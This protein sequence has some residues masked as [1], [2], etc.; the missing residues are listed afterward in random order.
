MSTQNWNG[1]IFNLGSG[2]N[3]SVNEVA[4]M[5]NPVSIKYIPAYPGEA[6]ETLADIS[7]TKEKLNWEPKYNLKDYIK[8]YCLK[9]E[10]PG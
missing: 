3:Y 1:E 8:N 9:L 4:K 2:I 7:F 6:W 5:F 10:L